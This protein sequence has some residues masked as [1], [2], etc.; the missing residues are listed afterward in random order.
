VEPSSETPS[1]PPGNAGLYVF[2]LLVGLLVGG[3][4]L[5]L[6]IFLAIAALVEGFLPNSMH[7]SV[8]FILLG[9]LPA[10]AIG[11]FGLVRTRHGLTFISG[12]LVGMA[13]G[14]LGGTAICGGLL[15]AN[16]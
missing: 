16:S 8:W 5:T 1:R 12:A 9:A 2:G 10:L 7:R 6:P 13:A 3:T 15:G 4:V 11:W 14:L